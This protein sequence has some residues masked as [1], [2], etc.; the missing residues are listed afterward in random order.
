MS[1]SQN[2]YSS[3]VSQVGYDSESHEL[4]ITW[5]R[6]KTRQT[7]YAGV[8]EELAVQLANA[9]SVGTMINNEIK[10]YYGYRNV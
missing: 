9:P 1:W 2:V 5:A 8:P 3:M 4:S 7:I 10:P 6:G